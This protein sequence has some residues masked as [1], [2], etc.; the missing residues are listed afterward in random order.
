MT[1]KQNLTLPYPAAELV[2]HQK[3]MLLVNMV[4]Q[5]AAENDPESHSIIEANAP[6]TGIFID[7]Q[8]I[9]QEYLIELMAQSIAAADG[10]KSSQYKPKP[11]KPNKGFL[12]GIDDFTLH[13]T[14]VPGAKLQ[15]KLKKTFT[16]GP[17]FI[18]A[19]SIH[20]GEQII[21]TGQ[22]KIWKDESQ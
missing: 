6:E 13:S 14:P 7:N 20:A 12:A 10:F 9:F 2:P 17:I 8:Q 4:I 1:R 21:A 18:F 19:G 11:N 15:I 16:F 22:V 3:P 5:I